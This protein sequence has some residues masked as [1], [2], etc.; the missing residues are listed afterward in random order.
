VKRWA[1][2]AGPRGTGKSSLAWRVVEALRARGVAVGGVIQDAVEREGERTGYVARRVM[3]PG[4]A[5]IARR[6]T[7][8][9]PGETAVCSFAFDEGA[10]AEVRGWL[11]NDARPAGILVIDEVSKLEASGSGHH[12]AIVDSL[13]SEALTILVVRADQLFFVMERFGLDE[14]VASLETTSPD[15]VERFVE[16]LASA[17]GAP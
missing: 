14:P 9:A 7:P 15:H 2:I 12:D 8:E 1:L 13:A 16:V 5:A 11:A 10:F 17:V 4:T 3:T 6:G